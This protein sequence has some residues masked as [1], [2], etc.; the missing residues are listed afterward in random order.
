ML[1]SKQISGLFLLFC[2]KEYAV[3]VVCAIISVCFSLSP[4]YEIL[5]NVSVKYRVCRT[6]KK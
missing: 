6:T 1:I 3:I 4:S 2:S 5:I